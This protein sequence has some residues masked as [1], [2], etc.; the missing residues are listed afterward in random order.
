M[1]DFPLSQRLEAAW[2]LSQMCVFPRSQWLE[3]LSSCL[4]QGCYIYEMYS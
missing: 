3:Q 1:Y 4:D 2:R